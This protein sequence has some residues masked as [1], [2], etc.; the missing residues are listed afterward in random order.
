[1]A[2]TNKQRTMAKYIRETRATAPAIIADQ[3]P[4]Y[5]DVWKI[6]ESVEVGMRRAYRGI[7]YEAVQAHTTQSDWTP[8]ATPAL[9]K[10][11]YT[12]EWP[13]WVQPTGAHDAYDLDAKVVHNGKKWTS[14]INAN[15][16]EPGVYGWNEVE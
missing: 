9:W 2:L 3:Y 5:Y 10:R 15:V 1:M 7:V 8:D 13:E 16:Y 4:E 6:S 14:I 12:E 11:V